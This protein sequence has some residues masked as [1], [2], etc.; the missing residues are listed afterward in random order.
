M[1][2][3]T[4]YI[5]TNSRTI[6]SGGFRGRAQRAPPL[7]PKIFSISCSFSQNLAKSYVGA[8][9][10]RLAPPPTGNPGS[11]PDNVH[12]SVILCKILWALSW[13]FVMYLLKHIKPYVIAESKPIW[14]I[15]TCASNTCLSNLNGMFINTGT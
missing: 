10:R 15:I 14:A 4:N 11:A 13:Y 8:P 7:R 12:K 3:F 6:I 9:P 1:I 5:Q 2:S